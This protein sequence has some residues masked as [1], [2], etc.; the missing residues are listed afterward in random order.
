MA[1]ANAALVTTSAVRPLIHSSA[2]GT[3]WKFISH[4][5][6]PNAAA[7]RGRFSAR[8]SAYKRPAQP[9]ASAR[10]VTPYPERPD[11]EDG[12]I[13]RERQRDQRTIES[14]VA[15]ERVEDLRRAA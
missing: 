6:D 13:R 8:S 10:L 4:T 12:G 3:P 1:V 14:R 11:A 7:S 2:I 9:T 5:A 15:G